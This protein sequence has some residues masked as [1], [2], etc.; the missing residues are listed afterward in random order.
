VF[1]T[2]LPPRPVP[3]TFHPGFVT[4]FRRAIY[5]E[6]GSARSFNLRFAG[7]Y[8]GNFSFQ[9]PAPVVHDEL[10]TPV[11]KYRDNKAS[12]YYG[13]WFQPENPL[14]TL[15]NSSLL[16]L[17]IQMLFDGGGR[18]GCAPST[19]YILQIILFCCACC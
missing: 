17:G 5:S 1:F 13:A 4:E 10:S 3:V 18:E 2:A 15:S 7:Y 12:R 19:A 9:A 11:G 6:P 16:P 8:G 14:H